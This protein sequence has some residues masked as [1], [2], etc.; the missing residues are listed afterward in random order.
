VR[1]AEE[2]R[3]DARRHAHLADEERERGGEE[4]AVP[5]PALEQEVIERLLGAPRRRAEV[6]RVLA[7]EGLGDGARLSR[8]PGLRGRPRVGEARGALRG[9]ARDRSRY[10]ARR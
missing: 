5:T 10:A 2:A 1:S 4:L 8:G 7:R 9:T 6:V 3:G